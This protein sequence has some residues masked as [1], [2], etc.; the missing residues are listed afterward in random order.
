MEMPFRTSTDFLF[1]DLFDCIRRQMKFIPQLFKHLYIIQ[2]LPL[3][4]QNVHVANTT[5]ET[6]GISVIL[7]HVWMY[8]N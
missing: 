1:R 4:N 2:T 6:V 8:S 3:S 5:G 7:R